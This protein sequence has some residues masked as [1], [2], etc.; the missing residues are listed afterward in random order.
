MGRIGLENAA[1]GHSFSLYGPPSGQITHIYFRAKQ[2][3]LFIYCEVI[4]VMYA[5]HLARLI[6]MRA[7]F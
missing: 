1:L 5:Y 2:R 4:P 3:L 6:I 7:S